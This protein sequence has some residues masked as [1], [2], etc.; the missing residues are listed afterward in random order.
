MYNLQIFFNLFK[1]ADERKQIEI[2]KDLLLKE[3]F[4][5][6]VISCK[7]KERTIWYEKTGVENVIAIAT[8]RDGLSLPLIMPKDFAKH[9]YAENGEFKRFVCLVGHSTN[10]VCA[11][12]KSVGLHIQL[13]KYY[14]ISIEKGLQLD[15]I[16]GHQGINLL[17]ELRPV[18]DKQN[19]YNKPDRKVSAEEAGEFAYNPLHDFRK[20]FWIPFLHYVLGVISKDDM[21]KLRAMEIAA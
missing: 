13:F 17:V 11:R 4:K 15:H 19:K 9:L 14:G 3:G 2:I 21:A 6:T 8:N 20:S 1:G 10:S 18:T 7:G 16:S 12:Y 5:K